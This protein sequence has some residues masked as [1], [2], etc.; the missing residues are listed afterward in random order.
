M[1]LGVALG[2]A[3]GEA[4]PTACGSDVAWG[5]RRG[6]VRDA[7]LL[8]ARGV[9]DGG[10][11]QHG[12]EHG[13]APLPRRRLPSSRRGGRLRGL[14]A[15]QGGEARVRPQLQRRAAARPRGLLAR[16]EH[17]AVHACARRFYLPY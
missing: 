15:D 2:E 14:P 3:L 10:L 12:P 9:P 5:A 8:T 4:L 6:R 1:A 16:A 13:S 7:S 17:D 11:A